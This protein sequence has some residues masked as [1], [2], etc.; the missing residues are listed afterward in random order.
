M[1]KIGERRLAIMALMETEEKLT[2]HGGDAPYL[3]DKV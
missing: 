1:L 2:K 3:E